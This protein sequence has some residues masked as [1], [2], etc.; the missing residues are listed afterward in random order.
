MND[1]TNNVSQRYVSKELTHFVGQKL[2]D[3][4]DQQFQLL[5]KILREGQLR[6]PRYPFDGPP[7]QKI[8]AMI[9][10]IDDP[11]EMIEPLMVSFCDIPIADM[12]IHMCKY[13]KFGLSFLKEFLVK[14][15]ANPVFYIAQNSVTSD[16]KSEYS[17]ESEPYPYVN[18]LALFQK[19][20][21]KYLDYENIYEPYTDPVDATDPKYTRFLNENH[22]IIKE[23]M[24]KV[25]LSR[26]DKSASDWRIIDLFLQQEFWSFVKFFDSTKTDQAN[27]NYYM[28]R[29]WR[30]YGR[31]DFK[32]E[33]VFR[34][35]LPNQ[36]AKNLKADFPD[37]CGQITF[38]DCL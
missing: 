12:Q 35:I 22:G 38:S 3:F 11:N 8:S 24:R 19:I 2:K 18:R 21:K 6:P 28:E 37:Y 34:I 1:Q 31:L 26:L 13:G 5:K 23:S 7:H 20:I 25:D 10:N 14:D 27:D 9:G 36:Y 30:I 33:N 15:G 32:L 4:D 16:V 29:E 17:I